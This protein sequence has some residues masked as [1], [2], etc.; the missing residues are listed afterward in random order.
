MPFYLFQWQ[1]KDPAIKAMTETP[2]DRPAE[3]RL[4]WPS[5]SVLL[6]VRRI[7]WGQHRRVSQ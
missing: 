6:R 4:R 1:Y 7:R 3:L 2:Q 5:A